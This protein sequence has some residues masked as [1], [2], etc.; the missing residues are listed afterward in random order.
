MPPYTWSW[1]GETVSDSTHRMFYRGEEI[2]EA[3]YRG[4]KIWGPDDDVK[5]GDDVRFI[6]WDG[7]VLYQMRAE[8]FIR[9]SDWPA[10]IHPSKDTDKDKGWGLH[11]HLLDDGWNWDFEAAQTFVRR[12]RYLDIGAEYATEN[13]A[14][15]VRVAISQDGGGQCVRFSG[16]SSSVMDINWGD[17]TISSSAGG[18][19]SSEY[20]KYASSGN[21]VITITPQI[22]G[23][24]A[25]Y[26]GL[27]AVTVQTTRRYLCS[28]EGLYGTGP[29]THNAVSVYYGKSAQITHGFCYNSNVR[30]VGFSKEVP[31]RNTAVGLWLAPNFNGVLIIPRGT[32]SFNNSVFYSTAN[33]IRV[34]WNGGRGIMDSAFSK[35][36]IYPDTWTG[37]SDNVANAVYWE[38]HIVPSS[39][40]SD[41]ALRN[42]KT[43]YLK[44]IVLPSADTFGFSPEISLPT[45]GP[46]NEE[47]RIYTEEAQLDYWKVKIGA[48]SPW[49]ERIEAIKPPL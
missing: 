25:I 42:V 48:N 31:V 18:G 44:K 28:L 20:H 3:Y 11:V 5:D 39:C 1:H 9:L 4:E 38:R 15:V 10:G 13:D 49:Y 22:E 41:V 30:Y 45:V 40:S 47:T 43:L 29:S 19:A 14:V 24:N 33:N 36:I 7:T 32:S 21:Y 37:P 17:G 26:G 16:V 23:T 27:Q 35:G 46:T 8:D 34:Y 2:K 6:D 12:Y